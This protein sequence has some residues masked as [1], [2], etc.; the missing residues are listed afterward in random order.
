MFFLVGI[1]KCGISGYMSPPVK[2]LSALEGAH[3]FCQR[4]RA[5]TLIFFITFSHRNYSKFLRVV[6]NKT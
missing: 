5:V 4:R 3:K 2:V 1:K 6:I